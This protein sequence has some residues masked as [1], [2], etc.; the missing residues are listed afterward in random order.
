[1]LDGEGAHV[2]SVAPTAPK[3]TAAGHLVWAWRIYEEG[4]TPV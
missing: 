1:M 3:H 2:P 4:F